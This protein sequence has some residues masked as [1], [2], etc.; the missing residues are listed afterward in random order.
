MASI[1]VL[2]INDDPRQWGDNNYSYKI[3]VE[4]DGKPDIVEVVAFGKKECPVTVGQTYEGEVT[5][6]NYG[7]SFRM[8]KAGGGG[9]NNESPEKQAS[10][11]RQNS[12][13]NSINYCTAK[14]QVLIAMGKLEAAEEELSGKHILQVATYFAGYNNGKLTIVMKP[15]EIAKVFGYETE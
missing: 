10:I 4:L 6:N 2:S 3:Q 9:K 11:E 7:K 5:S 12:L 15:N 13:T 8:K 14:A 1:K